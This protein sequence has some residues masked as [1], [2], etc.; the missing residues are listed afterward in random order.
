MG[1][2]SLTNPAVS[3]R[4]IPGQSPLEQIVEF[5]SF[6][7]DQLACLKRAIDRHGD[8]F[9]LRVLGYPIVVVN[10]PDYVQR[11]LV[12]NRENYNKN[13]L[14]YKTVRPALR[15]GLIGAIGG[16][17]WQRH[18]RLMQ[19]SFHRPKIAKFTTGMVEETATMVERWSDRHANGEVT[20]LLPD[21]T[22]VVLR[23]VMRTVF[24]LDIRHTEQMERDFTL[25]NEIMG[26]YF[27]FPFPP[28]NFPTPR[29]RR[30]MRL[31]A[32]VQDFVARQIEERRDGEMTLLNILAEAVDVE[33][34]EPMS[35]LQLRDEVGN[36][37]V[38]GYET[39]ANSV[40]F[41]LQVL[42]RRGDVQERMAAELATELGGR[43][44]AFEDLHRLTYT[45]MVVDEVL[46]LYS[47]A[48]QTMRHAVREDLV[49][50]YRIPA[51]TDIYINFH[52]LHRHPDFWPDPDRFD[53]ER[54]RP[55]AVAARP[56]NAYVPFASGPRH[57]IGKHFA[58]TELMII[59][60][61]IL[62]SFRMSVADDEPPIEFDQL[63][64]LRPRHG[65]RLRLERR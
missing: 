34:G 24:G 13:S 8:I 43:T 50:D 25:T 53:P 6:Q 10:H 16:E 44:P 21:L 4:R 30:L 26:N 32:G 14:I 63:I 58:V 56:K 20:E 15:D 35:A 27:R 54:F 17:L 40:A 65:L 7:R 2:V 57:C 42:A 31:I 3:A 23:I 18:R 36:V 59:V 48:W 9:R 51:G 5:R 45:R 64:T 19:P 47:P 1:A 46:R 29:N 28:L 12:E 41:M 49:G 61:M 33:T 22:R 11:V 60:S 55:G 62:R 37:M 52:T 38:G 39:T